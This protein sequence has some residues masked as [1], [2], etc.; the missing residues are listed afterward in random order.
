MKSELIM[1]SDYLNWAFVQ[2]PLAQTGNFRINN[3]FRYSEGKE[4]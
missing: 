4:K 1:S 2:V 3:Y